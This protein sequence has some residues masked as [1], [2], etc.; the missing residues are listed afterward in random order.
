MP[1]A[2]RPVGV[3]E[4]TVGVVDETVLE[5]SVAGVSWAAVAAG[6][7][8]S[9]ALTLVLL[10]LGAGLGFSVVS[11]WANFGVSQLPFRSAP[12]STSL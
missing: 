7:V 10:S 6:A 4:T 12:D 2:M 9:C 1:H 11:P 5:P 3:I 8:A